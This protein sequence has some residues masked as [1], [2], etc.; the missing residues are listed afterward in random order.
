M[1]DTYRT[2]SAEQR[3]EIDKVKGSRFIATAAPAANET[4][5]E[6]CLARVRRA[7]ADA[8][9]HCWAWRLG[10]DGTRF[11]SSDAGEPG[12]SAGR[13]ILRQIEAHGLTDVVVVVARYFGG[14]KL[15]V[16]GLVRAYTAAASAALSTAQARDVEITTRL[17]LT[18]PYDCSGEV[19]AVLSARNVKPATEE[20]GETVRLVVDLPLRTAETVVRELRDRTSGRCVA[21][22]DREER[23][24]R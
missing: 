10:P 18:H 8:T 4:E 16:G 3:R 24:S 14:T 23:E 9:H 6:A 20:Y 11:R 1:R 7:F 19:R 17:V 2:L 22:D 13:P 21:A 15:G 12:G 5:V